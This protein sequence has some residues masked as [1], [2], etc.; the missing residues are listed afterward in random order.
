MEE[1]VLE[2]VSDYELERGKPLPNFNHGYIQA[3]LI[4]S[5]RQQYGKQFSVVS[6]VSI[7][8]A[9]ASVTP[10]VLVFNK[11]PINWLETKPALTE[12]PIL[13]I[14]IQS[15]LHA[16]ETMIEKAKLLLETGVKSVWIIQPELQTVSVFSKSYPLK[17]FVE[18]TIVDKACGIEL[19]FDAIFAVE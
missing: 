9:S 15:P 18:G 10:D 2:V 11:R 12:P 17:T 19:S 5:L 7:P 13:A 4:V 8:T 1:Q 16:M 3:N 14:E 6:E